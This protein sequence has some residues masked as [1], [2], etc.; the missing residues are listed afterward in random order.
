MESGL[1]MEKLR[2]PQETFKRY[3]DSFDKIR[4]ESKC[5]NL[6]SKNYT[7]LYYSVTKTGFDYIGKIVHDVNT[8][9]YICNQE[10]L[11][12]INVIDITL[13][14]Q[15]MTDF[16]N[17][18]IQASNTGSIQKEAKLDYPNLVEYNI[19]M[20]SFERNH[21]D[22]YFELI[23]QFDLRKKILKNNRSNFA[24]IE[25]N[26]GVDKLFDADPRYQKL[27]NKLGDL[28]S[29]NC[30]DKVSKFDF[31]QLEFKD[32]YSIDIL[33]ALK[34][35]F[36][37]LYFDDKSINYYIIYEGNT[38]L[39][40]ISINKNQ[41]YPQERL[42]NKLNDILTI[43]NCLSASWVMDE[44]FN[45]NDFTVLFGLDELRL[46]LKKQLWNLSKIRSQ[47]IDLYILIVNATILDIQLQKVIG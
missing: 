23:G 44:E 39:F 14:K 26:N 29:Y 27:L 8:D 25:Y 37:I 6:D 45:D 42:G 7:D 33:L 9:F 31:W 10:Y 3:I 28:V 4:I 1:K 46:M 12:N 19:M 43:A 13:I 34:L 16:L 24:I 11:Q 17:R 21:Y 22:L 2:V 15:N 5:F 32:L 36:S 47:F 20:N 35:E 38:L 40:D 18:Y 30:S 41:E